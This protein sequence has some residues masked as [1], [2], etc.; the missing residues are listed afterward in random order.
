MKIFVLFAVGLF[1][2]AAIKMTISAA[3]QSSQ[4]KRELDDRVPSTGDRPI[5]AL[6]LV[7]VLPEVKL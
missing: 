6:S 1:T 5:Y 2:F 7:W 3:A 4:S